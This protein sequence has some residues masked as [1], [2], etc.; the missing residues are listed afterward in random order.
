MAAEVGALLSQAGYRVASLGDATR[1]RAVLE[2]SGPAAIVLMSR[3]DPAVFAWDALQI[4]WL[5]R[6]SSHLPIILSLPEASEETA[7]RLRGK[8]CTLLPAAL[9]AETLLATL[10]T[11]IDGP[12]PA[13]PTAGIS[14]G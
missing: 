3:R 10:A 4:L 6:H 7:A 1:L 14:L 13:R 2:Q 8:R 5:D 12:P 9:L 11:V